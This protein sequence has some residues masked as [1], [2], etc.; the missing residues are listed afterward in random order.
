[1]KGHADADTLIKG[2][3]NDDAIMGNCKGECDGFRAHEQGQGF[4]Q[5]AMMTAELNK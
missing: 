4:A 2:D 1:M 3:F 5:A